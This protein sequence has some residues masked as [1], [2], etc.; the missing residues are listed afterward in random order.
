M[1]RVYLDPDTNEWVH[2]DTGARIDAWAI[3]NQEPHKSAVE[4]LAGPSTIHTPY[5]ERIAGPNTTPG[6]V[7]DPGEGDTPIPPENYTKAEEE[8]VEK[9]LG[10]SVAQ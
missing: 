6:T 3:R 2:A 8:Y 9:L 4:K 7:D 1:A 5:S 10:G